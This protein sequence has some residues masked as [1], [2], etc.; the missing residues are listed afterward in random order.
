ME[1]KTLSAILESS[2]G[3]SKKGSTFTTSEGH[4]VTFYLGETIGA[5]PVQEVLTV[6]LEDGYVRLGQKEKEVFAT[7]AA[8]YVVEVKGTTAPGERKTGF[9]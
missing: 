5:M 3:F 8:V 4:R 7:Y 1:S 2:D 9:A 6:T